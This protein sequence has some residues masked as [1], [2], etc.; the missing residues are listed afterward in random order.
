MKRASKPPAR[1]LDAVSRGFRELCQ[2]DVV[3]VGMSALD[4][5][6]GLLDYSS[7]P[8]GLAKRESTFDPHKPQ[9]VAKRFLHQVALLPYN[10]TRISKRMVTS[11]GGFVSS[12]WKVVCNGRQWHDMIS[13]VS[14]DKEE[15]RET[16]R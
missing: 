12:R 14:M 1:A 8:G 13:L 3:R 16:F 4:V 2:R 11:T 5:G 10:A 6:D 9:P 15:S 7:S